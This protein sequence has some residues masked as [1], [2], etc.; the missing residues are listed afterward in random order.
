M[1]SLPG[2]KRIS[3][4]CTDFILCSC[5]YILYTHMGGAAWSRCWNTNVRLCC[6]LFLFYVFTIP[7][8]FSPLLASSLLFP[9]WF[10][11]LY[12][13]FFF[14]G[15]YPNFDIHCGTSTPK[16]VRRRH[17]PLVFV[18]LWI[19]NHVF[20][21]AGTTISTRQHRRRSV[22]AHSP[23]T[24]PFMVGCCFF[25]SISHLSWWWEV[26]WVRERWSRKN[27]NECFQYVKKVRKK[28]PSFTFLH[29]EN[30][31]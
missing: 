10:F 6:Y 20:E 22:L 7:L 23:R 5:P 30:T 27:I 19:V 8:L 3:G 9:C 31:S 21:Y 4:K 15:V 13:Y 28:V 25:I 16:D 11:L 14:W 26:Q 29:T 12:Y 17:F 2:V 24:T 18:S 1:N